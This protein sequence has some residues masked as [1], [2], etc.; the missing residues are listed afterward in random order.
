MKT[1][2]F[3]E[4]VAQYILDKEL[5]PFVGAGYSAYF[6]RLPGWADLLKSLIS[7]FQS[8]EAFQDSETF[9]EQVVQDLEEKISHGEYQNVANYIG[10]NID[11]KANVCKILKEAQAKCSTL[12]QS[13]NIIKWD[14]K[15]IITTNFDTLIE[16]NFNDQD[17]YKSINYL[18]RDELLNKDS[19]RKIIHIHGSIDHKES[20][21]FSES[22]I[23]N[24]IWRESFFQDYLQAT[25]FENRILFIGYSL[26]D[27]HIKNILT[28]FAGF[29]GDAKIYDYAILPAKNFEELD[30]EKNYNLKILRLD[31]DNNYLSEDGHSLGEILQLITE[32]FEK[33]AKINKAA[34]LE[35]NN[36]SHLSNV[37]KTLNKLT[38][39]HKISIPNVALL[40]LMI[41]TGLNSIED[42]NKTFSVHLVDGNLMREIAAGGEK[43][44]LRKENKEESVDLGVIG[45][46]YTDNLD[47]FYVPD[48]KKCSFYIP[49]NETSKSELVF[50]LK[51]N[52][53]VIGALNCESCETDD[54]SNEK[55]VEILSC[56]A[57]HIAISL[58]N[59]RKF[60]F[61]QMIIDC[62]K[63]FACISES[64]VINVFIRCINDGISFFTGYEFQG[65]LF[66]YP[67]ISIDDAS[68]E[69]FHKNIKIISMSNNINI[70]ERG[71]DSIDNEIKNFIL[72]HKY[73]LEEAIGF[74]SYV[75]S[76][77]EE[78]KPYQC[79]Y[80]PLSS[81]GS[82]DNRNFLLLLSKK[83]VFL[84]SNDDLLSSL[85]KCLQILSYHPI[86][87]QHVETDYA[88]KNI[89]LVKQLFK[90]AN[91]KLEI[92]RYFNRVANIICDQMNVDWCF[93]Y[94][95]ND[96]KKFTYPNSTVEYELIAF[97]FLVGDV[98]EEEIMKK[99][100][101][102]GEG[103]TGKTISKRDFV[104]SENCFADPDCVQ[105]D[106]NVFEVRGIDHS[107]FLG[108]PIKLFG[109]PK[110][111]FYSDIAGTITL[112]RVGKSFDKNDRDNLQRVSLI[113][114]N[115]LLMRNLIV[116]DTNFSSYISIFNNL[117]N[118]FIECSSE[119]EIFDRLSRFIPENLKED[120]YSIYKW[121]EDK[122]R[123]T[124]VA[125]PSSYISIAPR[126]C[127]SEEL[128]V[129]QSKS[130]EPPIFQSGCGLTGK[131]FSDGKPIFDPNVKDSPVGLQE[132]K[133]FWVGIIGV[134]DRPL[135]GLR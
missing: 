39:S 113:V 31:I 130:K 42:R 83:Q 124:M 77:I 49:G 14:C 89:S 81:I 17:K 67:Y 126:A 69:F 5:V 94:L 53:E 92:T 60:D 99:T 91:D 122:K 37:I 117:P 93:I 57:K 128:P 65:V 55:E 27:P 101:K 132:C 51:F 9:N 52:N 1:K 103:L 38:G 61:N 20:V 73:H 47:S 4:E 19:K 16:S 119:D 71:V 100:Y 96:S 112:G 30:W 23:S 44:T 58:V 86:L 26:K 56:L 33:L 22:D 110:D 24:C 59:K 36:V 90:I 131:V 104:R 11:F 135:L 82:G 97:N 8:S 85:K 2:Q 127:L 88:K 28:H 75:I 72:K 87:T 134:E 107:K 21:I 64:E 50:G 125:A 10:N 95:R 120:Y 54:F 48:V 84:K 18:N 121:D 105:D 76:D 108:Y 118:C 123:L 13:A 45:R 98:A 111:S 106:R 133:E 46:V 63:I 35:K 41:K 78:A 3:V 7:E 68:E 6:A 34:Y 40:D 114:G 102:P 15:K 109:Y 32:E 12:D 66:N 25:F 74:N 79:I 29:K 80:W 115:E 62:N 116:R 129:S 70:L 43:K